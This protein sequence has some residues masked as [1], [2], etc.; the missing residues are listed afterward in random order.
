[1]GGCGRLS[2]LLINYYYSTWA[3]KRGGVILRM[4]SGQSCFHFWGGGLKVDKVEVF[5]GGGSGGEGLHLNLLG[6]S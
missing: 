4:G 3:C 2:V 6:K 1:M 5:E